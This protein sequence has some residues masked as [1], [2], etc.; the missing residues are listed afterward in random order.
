MDVSKKYAEM[1]NLEYSFVVDNGYLLFETQTHDC[2]KSCNELLTIINESISNNITSQSFEINKT[3]DIDLNLLLSNNLRS[4][5][6]IIGIPESSTYL[7][8]R[9]GQH[10]SINHAG[11]NEELTKIEHIES[12]TLKM[13]NGQFVFFHPFALYGIHLSSNIEWYVIKSYF[14][15]DNKNVNKNMW[16]WWDKVQKSLDLMILTEIKKSNVYNLQVLE[17][18]P[19]TDVFQD[20]INME[21]NGIG[22]FI[23]INN[24]NIVFRIRPINHHALIK[25]GDPSIYESVIEIVYYYNMTQRLAHSTY[26]KKDNF[27][28]RTGGVLSRS[29]NTLFSNDLY[30]LCSTN[31]DGEFS[32]N[33][34]KV[35]NYFRN[36]DYND[37]IKIW[38]PDPRKNLL[39]NT[40]QDKL[41]DTDDQLLDLRLNFKKKYIISI[42]KFEIID[43]RFY[44]RI[45]ILTEWFHEL[46]LKGGF[47]LTDPK[48]K[49][50]PGF[51]IVGGESESHVCQKKL[52]DFK[53]FQER[54]K[55]LHWKKVKYYNANECFTKIN[56][57]MLPDDIFCIKRNE[58][59]NPIYNNIFQI[60][61]NI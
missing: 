50:L 25:L 54:F 61:K 59:N 2:H 21:K 3:N 60:I 31:P 43:E 28:I 8:I 30:N 13:S 12:Y 18:T 10:H 29:C 9:P 11:S 14:N 26:T 7:H 20:M 53:T 49:N 33:L 17:S 56:Y 35:I 36:I 58:F 27:E 32:F 42:Y 15:E 52:G 4:I 45:S 48:D 19:I 34:Q 38:Y 1:R 55:C 6:M 47:V 46:N 37:L 23:K 44:P 41:V 51:M 39:L 57:N 24:D 5:H 16:Y 40:F 22:E